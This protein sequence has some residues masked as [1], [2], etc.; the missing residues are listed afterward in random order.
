MLVHSDPVTAKKL[1]VSAQADVND[2][3]KF[4][5]QL[6]QMT[7]NPAAVPETA[8]EATPVEKEAHA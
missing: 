7:V 5:E 1:L 2:K 6:A 3:W 8:G 4:Y